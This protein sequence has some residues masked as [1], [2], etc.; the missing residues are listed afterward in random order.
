MFCFTEYF[1]KKNIKKLKNC[2]FNSSVEQMVLK[3]KVPWTY[4]PLT[5][6]YPTW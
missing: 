1:M 6:L 4:V 2:K 3:L 5:F